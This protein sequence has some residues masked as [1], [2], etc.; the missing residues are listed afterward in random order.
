MADARRPFSWKQFR[1]PAEHTFEN[2][3]CKLDET[4]KNLTVDDARGHHQAT[5]YFHALIDYDQEQGIG[6]DLAGWIDSANFHHAAC[7]TAL[8]KLGMRTVHN[9]CTFESVSTHILDEIASTGNPLMDAEFRK[10]AASMTSE[11]Q[12][13]VCYSDLPD[14][15]LMAFVGKQTDSV[16][17]SFTQMYTVD[18][19]GNRVV[20]STLPRQDFMADMPIFG[21]PMLFH[22]VD[23]PAVDDEP[24]ASQPIGYDSMQVVGARRG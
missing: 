2:C 22:R 15:S 10:L 19:D 7:V 12:S 8:C 9:Q 3:D 21:N 17:K 5:N 4:Y 18:A 16:A 14:N 1:C 20:M 6:A 11:P 23:P 24:L 13:D